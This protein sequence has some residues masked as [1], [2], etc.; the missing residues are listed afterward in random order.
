MF[1]LYTLLN[2]ALIIIEDPL[3]SNCVHALFLSLSFKGGKMTYDLGVML[4]F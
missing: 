1:S 4:E 3:L 2:F